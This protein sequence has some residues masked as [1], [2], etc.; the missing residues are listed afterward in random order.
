M[1]TLGQYYTNPE[2]AQECLHVLYQVLNNPHDKVFLEPSAGEGSFTL[3][4]TGDGHQVLG[5]DIEPRHESIQQRDFFHPDTQ[6]EL[7]D[8]C[9][10]N[11]VIAVGNP[12][13][14]KRARTALEFVNRTLDSGAAAVAMILPAQFNKYGTQKKL[15]TAAELIH[16]T[17]VTGFY[18]CTS[19]G[20]TI[21][22]TSVRCYWHIWVTNR[23]ILT[24]EAQNLPDLRVRTKP[25]TTH[26]DFD[27]WQHNCTPVS[28]KYL[29]YPWDIAV[30]RQGWGSMEPIIQNPKTREDT[31]V[32]DK[33][34]QWMLIRTHT[35][36]AHQILTSIDYHAL[37]D[38][39]TTVRGFGKA[40][41]VA[42]Y[43]RVKNCD[44]TQ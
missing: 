3:P 23:A 42:E 30:L 4:L 1:S 14:G 17:P 22:Y 6:A 40:D 24:P 20:K 21:P 25:A 35:P 31:V 15:P 16:S 39:N 11:T 32:L 13:F 33:R 27:M 34:K 18:Q 5:W 37:G 12:P 36:E 28:E 7:Y 38:K 41:L 29:T 26:P 44:T 43:E 9:A 2:V 8:L 19:S 10:H